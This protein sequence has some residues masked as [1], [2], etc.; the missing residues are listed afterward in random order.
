MTD[1]AYIALMGLV[2]GAAFYAG[3]RHGIGSI[4]VDAVRNTYFR[5]AIAVAMAFFAVARR[6]ESS[7]AIFDASRDMLKDIEPAKGD[8]RQEVL[9]M[10]ARRLLHDLQVHESNCPIIEEKE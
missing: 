4:M 7:Q 2:G 9:A 5:S 8:P 3:Y 10:A 6:H 1:L